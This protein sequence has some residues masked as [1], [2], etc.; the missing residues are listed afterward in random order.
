[1]L[2]YVD[3]MF[4]IFLGVVDITVERFQIPTQET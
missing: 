2:I 4:I 3:N 1:M